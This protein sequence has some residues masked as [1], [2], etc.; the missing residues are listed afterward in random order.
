[1]ARFLVVA[2]QTSE[3]PEFV[4]AIRRV[5]LR[6]PDGEFVLLVPATP[7]THLAGWTEGEAYA[8]ASEKAAAARAQLEGAGVTVADVRVGDPN[9]YDA[10]LDALMDEDFDEVIVSTL[11]PGVSRWLGMDLIHRLQRALDLPV[12]HVIAS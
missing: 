11:P 8:V 7:V 2:H 4:E 3:A 6:H 10:V 5:S 9:P 1:M 12:T